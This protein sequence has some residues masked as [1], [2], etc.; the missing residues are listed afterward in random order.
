MN[1]LGFKGVTVFGYSAYDMAIH[2]VVCRRRASASLGFGGTAGPSARLLERVLSESV[3]DELVEE[4]ERV[5]DAGF[6][7]F[8]L[9]VGG[10]SLAEDVRR[11]QA[12][13]DC[14]PAGTT[15]MLDAVQAWTPGRAI[16]ASRAFAA[17]DPVW[18]EDPLIHHDYRGL[19]EVVERFPGADRNR[20]E[21]VPVRRLR[22][23]GY[24]S[25]GLLSG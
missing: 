2:D 14:A 22:S 7:A 4:A 3:L 17:F 1:F 18:L 16:E 13:V 11:V 10:P 5:S 20:R 21:R 8:K 6:T 12:I 25:T 9:R 24:R 23:I 15:I 19:G